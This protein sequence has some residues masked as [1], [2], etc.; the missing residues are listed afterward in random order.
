MALLRKAGESQGL[1]FSPFD[2]RPFFF[3]SA[4]IADSASPTG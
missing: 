3:A 4:P 1:S 2:E